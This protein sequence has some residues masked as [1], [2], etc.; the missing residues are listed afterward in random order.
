MKVDEDTAAYKVVGRNNSFLKSP[1]RTRHHGSITNISSLSQFQ[2]RQNKKYDPSK[3]AVNDREINSLYEACKMQK[4]E[5]RNRVNEFYKHIDDNVKKEMIH[6]L[7]LQQKIL[8]QKQFNE[9]KENRLKNYFSNKLR[10]SDDQILMNNIYQYR[11]RNELNEFLEINKP[12]DVNQGCI[13]WLTSLRRPNDFK[14]IR[15]SYINT[16]DSLDSLWQ[17][18]KEEIPKET[19]IVRRPY[20][21]NKSI[22][23]SLSSNYMQS[24]LNLMNIG[25]SFQ[26]RRNLSCLSVNM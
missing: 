20:K 16:K 14:G 6:I 2:T 13:H 12:E 18:V 25:D 19:E 3:V 21:I 10:K 1:T 15:F 7:S 17:V 26:H 5:N 9:I 11:E 23:K 24:K 4:F 8:T 22:D